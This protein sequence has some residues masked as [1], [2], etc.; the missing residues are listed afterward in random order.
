MVP[1]LLAESSPILE[2]NPGLMIWVLVTFAISVFVLAKFA[3]KPIQKALD[4]RQALIAESIDAAE[5]TRAESTKMLSEYRE[6]LAAARQE[7]QSI[8]D[9]ARKVGDELQAKA[10]ADAEAKRQQELELIRTQVRTEVEKAMGELR[11]GVAEM[12]VEATEKVLRGALDVSA[13]K[14][15]IEQAVEELDFNRLQKVGASR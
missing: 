5:R 9:G 8:V 15:L 14:Q 4:D 6:Q 7:A 11:T 3:F 10:K 1:T 13:H 2:P 12:T